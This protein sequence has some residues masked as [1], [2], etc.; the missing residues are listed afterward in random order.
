M[1]NSRVTTQFSSANSIISVEIP[2]NFLTLLLVSTRSCSRR[3][4]SRLHPAH[5]QRRN[6]VGPEDFMEREQGHV[7]DHSRSS[8]VVVRFRFRK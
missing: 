8:V 1:E 2:D 5:L 3:C 6:S 7:I 4:K